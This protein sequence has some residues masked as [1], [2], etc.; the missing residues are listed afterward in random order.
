LRILLVLGRYLPDK[1]GGI[2]N[3]SHWLAKLLIQS[4]H[5]V[6]VAILESKNVEA[7]N[8]ETVN[9]FPLKNGLQSFIQ[10]IENKHYDICHFQEYSGKNGINIQW[11]QIAKKYCGKV[12]FTFHLPY[13]TCYKND[14]RVFGVEDCNNF[15]SPDRCIKCIIGTKLHYNKTEWFNLINVG[16]KAIIPVIEKTKKIGILRRNIRSNTNHITELLACCDNIFVIAS[17]FK[18]LLEYNGFNSSKII[19]IPP[20]IAAPNQLPISKINLNMKLIYIGRIEYQKG[21]HLLCKAL[22][23]MS[24]KVDLDVFGNI[25]NEEYFGKCQHE[26]P[27]NF[28]GAVSRKDLL[29]KLPD[30][31]FLILPSVCTEMNPLVIQE[32]IGTRLPVIASAAKGNVAVIEEGKN[33]FIFDYNNFKDLARVIDKGYKLKQNGWRPEFQRKVSYERDLKEILSYYE[34]DSKALHR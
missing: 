12:Y 18:E 31:D 21:L 9:V 2:E 7:Y 29:S 6:D 10:L 33:G 28:K 23:I 16:I 3:Y 15:S 5:S 4:Y 17:W 32:A 34:V 27:F 11:F 24:T 19:Y 20:I 13:F 8:F 26:F 22:N 25:E 1:S 14:F 30:Y